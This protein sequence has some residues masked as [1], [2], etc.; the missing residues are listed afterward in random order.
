MTAS[1]MFP[2]ASG[3]RLGL[4]LLLAFLALVRE[5]W[6]QSGLVA[7]EQDTLVL[8]SADGTAHE[9]EVELALTSA[10]H[11]QGLMFRRQMAGDAGMLFIYPSQRMRYM[12]MKNTLIPLDMLFIDKSGRVVHLVERAV[13]KSLQTISSNEPVLAVLELNGGTA[14]RLNLGIGDVV[15]HAAF[16]SP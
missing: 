14:S 7:F 12:W 11:A 10:Q 6:A 13:P 15:E 16:D 5:G 3:L 2:A 9:F 4:I 1:G 8:R